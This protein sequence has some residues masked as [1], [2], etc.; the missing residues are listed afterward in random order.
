MEGEDIALAWLQNQAPLLKTAMFTRAF[1]RPSPRMNAAIG[2]YWRLRREFKAAGGVNQQSGFDEF[3]AT[4]KKSYKQFLAGNQQESLDL[5]GKALGLSPDRT[6]Q[7]QLTAIKSS[8]RQRL[9]LEP[10]P[11]ADSKGETEG[12][13]T[14]A[15]IEKIKK[16]LGAGARAEIEKHDAIV[17]AYIAHLELAAGAE[18]RVKATYHNR[19]IEDAAVR[20]KLAEAITSAMPKTTDELL[21]EVPMYR[22][23]RDVR[24]ATPREKA[25]LAGYDGAIGALRER[26]DYLIRKQPDGWLERVHSYRDRINDLSESALRRIERGAGG[27]PA[28]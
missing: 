19:P 27:T 23:Y 12:M 17:K 3:R 8:L 18:S 21:A 1:D 11:G 14:T 20:A 25:I 5:V 26:I 13:L 24:A 22:L 16:R 15:K 10:D 6:V 4:M 28:K 9:L 2:A 7:E